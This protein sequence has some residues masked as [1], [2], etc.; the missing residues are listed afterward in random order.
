HIA[1]PGTSGP[2]CLLGGMVS[3]PLCPAAAIDPAFE[4]FAMKKL[5]RALELVEKVDQATT[6]KKKQRL[7][8][9][10]AKRL[11]RIAKERRGTT[12]AD[13]LES[14]FARVDRVLAAIENL[15]GR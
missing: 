14:L 15:R 6:S 2:S 8:G 10:A 12:T 3:G 11:G 9:N 5:Q 7:L 4:R 1:I 13:C